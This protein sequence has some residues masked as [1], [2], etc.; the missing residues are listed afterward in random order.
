MAT[1]PFGSGEMSGRIRACDWASTPLGPIGQWPQS[2]KTA[3]DLMLGSGHAMQLA[4][5][6][7]KIVLYNDAYAPMLGERHPRALGIAFQEAWPEIWDEIEPLV[8]KVF[9]GETVRFDDMPLVM[10]RNGYAE[11]TW[12]NFSYSPVRDESG[13]VAGLLNVTVDATP[14]HRAEHAERE[15]MKSLQAALAEAERVR[16]ELQRDDAAKDRFL[17]VLS[18]ELRNPLTSISGAAQVLGIGSVDPVSRERAAAIIG[19][20]TQ[21]MKVL[22]DDLLDLSRLRLG[23]LSLKRQRV[24]VEEVVD[25]ALDAARAFM[26]AFGHTLVL[27]LQARALVLDGDPVRLAQ[28]LSNLLTN[29]AKY[30]PPGGRIGLKTHARGADVVIEISDSG[31]GMEPALVDGM[32]EMFAQGAQAS[33]DGGQHGLGIGLALVRSI[34]ELHGGQVEGRS[35]GP[36][37]GSRF[38]VTLPLAR[39]AQV[40]EPAVP[41]GNAAASVPPSAG[42]RVLLVDDNTDATWSLSLLLEGCDTEAANT[43]ARGLQLARQHM[44]DVAVLD[45]GLP[46]MSGLDLARALR[47]LPGGDRLLLVAATGWGQESDREQSRAAGF[48]AHLVKPIRIEVLKEL[49]LRHAQAG[50]VG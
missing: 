12:W 26:D 10:T 13:A 5:G 23:K 18:H 48:D 22:L 33:G 8:R 32:F 35:D 50:S 21:A 45:L 17:A 4:W 43:A 28:V 1:W 49:V 3:V 30:T 38:I 37:L 6:P 42:P 31:I 29:A 24:P 25:S 19:R 7:Q 36:G 20:Q 44:P 39:E 15:T 46:D 47:A 11:N 27:D 2:L 41:S 34:V 14:R 9:A 16:A 40:F